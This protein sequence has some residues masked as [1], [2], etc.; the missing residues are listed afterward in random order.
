MPDNEILH[1]QGWRLATQVKYD[2]DDDTELAPVIV[3]AVADVKG[4]D[5]LD[6]AL[7]PLYDSLDTAALEE[8]FFGLS[9]TR[10]VDDEAGAVTFTYD[11]FRVALKSDGWI[12]VYEP[13]EP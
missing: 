6:S 3:R 1:F 4:V 11:G 5:L 2:R 9:E 10:T 8:T 13:V 12:F 7:P